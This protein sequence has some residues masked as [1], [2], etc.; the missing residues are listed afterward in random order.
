MGDLSEV[1]PR[2]MREAERFVAE[3]TTELATELTDSLLSA[4]LIRLPLVSLLMEVREEARE[5]SPPMPL[6]LLAPLFG[7]LSADKGAAEI[8]CKGAKRPNFDLQSK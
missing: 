4:R 2:R 5:E 6:E 8:L 7:L 1:M 3:E